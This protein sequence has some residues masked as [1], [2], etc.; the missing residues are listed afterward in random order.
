MNNLLTAFK[1]SVGSA[2]IKAVLDRN[3]GAFTYE[4]AIELKLPKNT[5][6]RKLMVS[7]HLLAAAVEHATE[8]REGW[9]V[10]VEGYDIRVR[11]G[12]IAKGYVYMEL[13]D[14]SD[15]EAKRAFALLSKV[16]AEAFR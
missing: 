7:L 6:Y 12:N 10:R 1:A 11:D 16:V 15:A 8:E 9:I 14:G 13:R 3:T 2:S 4:P 5:P